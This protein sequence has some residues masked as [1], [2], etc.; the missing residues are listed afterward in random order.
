V[1]VLYILDEPSIGLHQRDNARLL[2]AL[3]RLRDLGN[4]VLVVEHDEETIRAADHVIDMGPKAGVHGGRIVAAGKPED[5]ENNPQSLTGA[6][7]SGRKRIEVPR[8]R[9]QSA[10]RGLTLRRARGHNLRDLTVSFP[11]G[12]LTCVTGVSGSGKSTLACTAPRRRRSRTT[13]WR[14]CSTSTR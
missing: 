12:V 6:Y 9:R 10:N 4:T 14:G 7:L 13:G 5:I 8:Q 2:Q 1:G 11:L 3:T